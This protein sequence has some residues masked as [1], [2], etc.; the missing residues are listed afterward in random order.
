MM[1]DE[2]YSLK[3]H[4]SISTNIAMCSMGG[5]SVFENIEMS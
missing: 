4:L 3:F 2:A 1:S 5:Y